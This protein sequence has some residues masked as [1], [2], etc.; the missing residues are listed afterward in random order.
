M[1]V[2]KRLPSLSNVAAGS[3]AVL[4]L[5]LG[6]TY[7]NLKLEYSGITLAQMKNIQLKAN[8]KTFQ[9]FKDGN[10]IDA[11]NKYYGRQAAN[12]LLTLWFVQP[13]M[14]TARDERITAL[15]TADLKTLTLEFDVDAAAANPQVKAHALQS[16]A[17]PFGLCTKILRFP[18]NSA[19]TG[20]QEID[21]LPTGSARIKAIHLFKPDV[22]KVELE[23]NGFLA[24][25]AEKRLS[26][27]NQKDYGRIPQSAAATHLDFVLEGDMSQAV[28]TQGV[29]DFRLRQTLATAGATNIVVEY[30]DG[31]AGI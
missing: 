12:G 26:E 20:V 14:K 24:Y 4:N 25:E 27:Q 1:R 6:R 29:Q 13:E 16:E 28:V 7:E 17:S 15:G 10:E 19:V 3:T 21:N 31:L 2:T 8:G 5:P 9:K 23:L 30:Y 18:V 22:S 11:I